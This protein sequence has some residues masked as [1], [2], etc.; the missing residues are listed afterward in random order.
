MYINIFIGMSMFCNFV[1]DFVIS[2]GNDPVP[3]QLKWDEKYPW[4]AVVTTAEREKIYNI[5]QIFQNGEN[6]NSFVERK[7]EDMWQN[8]GAEPSQEDY[9]RILK[10]LK[11]DDEILNFVQFFKIALYVT[12]KKN[13]INHLEVSFNKLQ[14]GD[15]ISVSEFR[16][17]LTKWNIDAISKNA[18][19]ITS[20][21]D[22][23][24]RLNLNDIIKIL[25]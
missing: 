20:I 23:T 17:I 10:T 8:V 1:P 21:L 19:N 18:N 4:L 7:N 6:D 24:K 9:E 13:I 3:Q 5:F 25:I 12:A 11:N 14:N 16:D 2:K 15:T 22:N